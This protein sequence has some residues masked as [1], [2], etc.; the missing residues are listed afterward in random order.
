[1]TGMN[2]GI[3]PFIVMIKKEQINLLM[4]LMLIGV[5]VVKL[6]NPR[7]TD[8]NIARGFIHLHQVGVRR[9]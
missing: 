7:D 2:V 1:M 9:I 6:E 5:D 8:D 3:L 4:T